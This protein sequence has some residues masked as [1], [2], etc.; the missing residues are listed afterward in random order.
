[1]LKKL[2]M[3]LAVV[4]TIASSYAI[5]GVAAETAY[6]PQISNERGVKITV[7][8]QNIPNGAKTWDVEVALETHTQSLSDDLTKSSV[9]MA[10]GKQYTP[11]S[12]DG[13]A[14]GGHHRK[15]LLRFKAIAPQPRL[16]ELQIRL[17]GDTSPRSFKW[18]LK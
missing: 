9:L 10:D 2:L 16:M 17:T 12:W 3:S 6:A 5:E 11:L 1:M 14:P 8:L 4:A 13:T 15:G 7:A 18:L